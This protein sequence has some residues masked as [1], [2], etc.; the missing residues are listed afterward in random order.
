MNMLACA[1]LPL[2]KHGAIQGNETKWTRRVVPNDELGL[3]WTIQK[4]W[5][6]NC[7]IYCM[8]LLQG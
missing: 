4:A 5:T 6:I 8:N 7:P 3:V 2:I 1:D